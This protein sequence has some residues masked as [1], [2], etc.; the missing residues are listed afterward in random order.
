MINRL[1][2]DAAGE[3]TIGIAKMAESLYVSVMMPKFGSSAIS[4]GV[5][6]IGPAILK[7]DSGST[8]ICVRMGPP[9][10]W[11]MLY[12][13]Q[14]WTLLGMFTASVTLKR[15]PGPITYTPPGRRASVIGCS[16]CA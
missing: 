15:V 16:R 4:G 5:P 13:C 3:L 1:E 9:G 2:P 6:V 11:V 12:R 7:R 14:T 10:G 8:L